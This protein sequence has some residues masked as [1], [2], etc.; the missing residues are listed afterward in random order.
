MSKKENHGDLRADRPTH[1]RGGRA[2]GI[3][4]RVSVNECHG[5]AI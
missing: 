1:G 3:Y 5:A 2:I 4:L